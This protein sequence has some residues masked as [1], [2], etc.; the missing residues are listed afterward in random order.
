[1]T[2][3]PQ[4][5]TYADRLAGDLPG[6]R[7]LLDGPLAGAFGGVHVLPF[8]PPFDGA[9]AGFDPR[10][11]TQV[12]PRLGTWDD[13]RALGAGREVMADVIVNHV[14]ADSAQF[15]D[16]RERG[17]AS[18]HAPMFLTLGAVFPDGASEE[19]LARIYRPR[20]GLPFT[21]MTL[22]GRRRLVW[23]TFTPDQV[24]LDLRT[25][26]AWEYLTAVVDA[27]TAGGVTMLRLDAVGYTGKEAG[28]DCF[29][30]PATDAYTERIVSLARA[31]GAQVL[32][33]V[34]GHHTQQIEIARKVDLVY[35]FALPPLVLHALTA[36]DLEPL[37]GWLAI[38]PANAVTVLDT[39]DGI[40]IVD[41]GPSDLRPGEPGL[42]APEKIDALVETMHENSGGTSRQATGAAASNLDLYQVNCTFYD[43]LARD[44]RRYLLARLLQL[45]V[46][47]IPQVYYVGLLAGS[48]DMEL[49]AAT[50]VGR[51]VNRHHYTDGEVADALARP[52]VRAQ[53]AALRLR[54]SHAA[55]GGAFE[56]DLDGTR[57]C[58]AWTAGDERAV[59]TFDVADASF[60]VHATGPDGEEAVLTDAAVAP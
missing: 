30:T 27:L 31:R 41:V 15:R 16:V 52:V 59:L 50:G 34:H 37:A 1:M 48:N 45:F 2:H 21:V 11:H 9:D 60:T 29:M 53:L 23:T 39:H 8:Y 54:A 7:A 57:G 51:D 22:G 6:L 55:F 19:D 13:V 38:R 42:L 40:G 49:L 46:P 10:D 43:A 36:A 3:G 35:D 47:G 33:E 24:D 18:P 4:L 17:D 32:V 5:I 12:D 44:D 56:W 25:P 58:L 14:S 28:T 26:Q 20:P